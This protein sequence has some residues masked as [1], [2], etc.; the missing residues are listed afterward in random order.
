M[1]QIY[2]YSL[3]PPLIHANLD[4]SGKTTQSLTDSLDLPIPGLSLQQPH[5]E[6]NL[7]SF[8]KDVIAI[9]TNDN[10]QIEKELFSQTTVPATIS[11]N[12]FLTTPIKPK[13][14]IEIND[15]NSVELLKSL[16]N[17]LDNTDLQIL[18]MS[19][20]ILKTRSDHLE[21]IG[22]LLQSESVYTSSD[23]Q[24]KKQETLKTYILDG[25]ENEQQSETLDSIVEQ[26][27]DSHSIDFQVNSINDVANHN[28]SNNSISQ[29]E[30]V[31]PE[32]PK[33]PVQVQMELDSPEIRFISPTP[34]CEME[35]D[36][37]Y[38]IK[39]HLSPSQPFKIDFDTE[40]KSTPFFTCNEKEMQVEATQPL[41]SS[42]PLIHSQDED[43][44]MLTTMI[45]KSKQDY[46][47]YGSDFDF[48]IKQIESDCESDI[49][50]NEIPTVIKQCSDLQLEKVNKNNQDMF[51]S[52]EEVEGIEMDLKT[53]PKDTI[54]ET[55]VPSDD[56]SESAFKAIDNP[57]ETVDEL[58]N[59]KSGMENKLLN[60]QTGTRDKLVNDTDSSAD[61]MEA[62]K[63][64]MNP[65][66]S[67]SQELTSNAMQKEI[68]TDFKSRTR[69]FNDSDGAIQLGKCCQICQAVLTKKYKTSEN[70]YFCNKCYNHRNVSKS[71]MKPKEKCNTP[72]KFMSSPIRQKPDSESSTEPD[73]SDDEDYQPTQKTALKQKKRAQT[74]TK[75]KVKTEKGNSRLFKGYGFILSYSTNHDDKKDDEVYRWLNDK[76]FVLK[77]V[78]QSGGTVISSVSTYF[79]GRNQINKTPP[80][81][82][83]IAS[84]PLRTKKYLMAD[85]FKENKLLE[86]D[87]YRLCNGESLVLRHWSSAPVSNHGIFK[88]YKVHG[89]LN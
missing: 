1:K 11:P 82:L 45:E 44:L 85:S 63:E 9:D 61:H 37:E 73:N 56:L 86:F 22:Y 70:E 7:N 72:R 60:E 16:D 14:V 79:H 46:N 35:F 57:A 41:H 12:L 87:T 78:K 76:E 30:N 33:P 77:Q 64:N 43:V 89:K 67:G 55:N 31:I 88:G 6:F 25:Q 18:D 69:K 42:N 36:S 19:S 47:D 50:A 54:P 81:I 74:N 23:F 38:K 49:L 52:R 27:K 40:S 8:E 26:T 51:L 80:F 21:N 13:E 48:S 83:L 58:V 5:E 68:A 3:N 10:D 17:S 29:I 15:S 24:P 71:V 20:D 39:L 34:E 62:V 84:R 66:L 65:F 32:S 2:K 53:I 75:K 59:E 28:I 4:F